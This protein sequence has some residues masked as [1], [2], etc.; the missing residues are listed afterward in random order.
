[1]RLV[2]LSMIKPDMV[3]AK[4]IYYMD[5]LILHEGQPNLIRYAD[6]L[7]K[8]GIDYVYVEDHKSD[9]IEIPDA[10]T[11]K[12]R[13]T[14]MHVLRE[15][16]TDFSKNATL[17]LTPMN[18]AVNDI[19]EEILSNEDVQV[20]LNDISAVDDYTF[21]HSVSTTVYALLIAKQLNYSRSMLTKLAAGTILHDMGKVLL[22]KDILFKEADLTPDEFE[23]IKQ[24]TTLGY[25]ALKK[26]NQLTELSKIISLHHHERMDGSGYPF[27][28]PAGQ[29]H[30]FS[31]IV[32]IADV[33]DAI[34]SD[35]CYRKKWSAIKAVNY[36]IECSD[37]K[38]DTDLVAVFIQQIAVYPNGSLVRLSNQRMGIVKDQNKSM[39]L[40]PIVR[41]ISDE[42]GNDIERYEIDLM[43]HLSI[44][45]LDSEMEKNTDDS[46]DMVS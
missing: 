7:R 30:E 23:Y 31:R 25:E 16:L 8:M 27:G 26:C 20:S 15:T 43:E 32:A 13:I 5:C 38:F 40:R 36:L 42:F 35:R 45:I 14:C 6:R 24:H 28:I 33:Y 17:D 1:M 18:E 11:Q 21:A 46:Q 3:L 41:V 9:G 37:T 12:T 19:I 10:V 39:P 34:T 22:D 29:L 2:S 4:S 44:T